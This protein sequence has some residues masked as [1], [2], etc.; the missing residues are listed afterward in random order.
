[1][2]VDYKDYMKKVAKLVH[3]GEE[4]MQKH[5][6]DKNWVMSAYFLQI[7]EVV[8]AYEQQKDQADMVNQLQQTA[9]GD[10]PE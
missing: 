4:D 6:D 10:D 7:K 8:F 1:M 2:K 5:K 9:S 3:K